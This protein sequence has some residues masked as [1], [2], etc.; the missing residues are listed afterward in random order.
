MNPIRHR[1]RCLHRIFLAICCTLGF[2]VLAFPPAPHQEVYGL[3]RDEL[4]NPVTASGATV[5]LEANGNILAS[6]TIAM[7]T[8]PGVNYRLLIA[9]D[10]G[11]T[12]DLYKPSALVPTVPFR[13]R[14]KIGN[15]TY[16]PIELSGASA[17]VAQPGK[18]ARVDLTLGVDSNGDGL[19]DAWQYAVI[20]AIGK[21]GLTLADISPGGDADGDGMTNLQEFLA[22]TYAFDPKDGFTVAL[23]S[24]EGTSANL[25]FTV[26]NRRSYTVEGSNDLHNWT[27]LSFVVPSEGATA[28]ARTSYL[29]T[30]TRVLRV[31]VGPF[32]DEITAPKFFRLMVY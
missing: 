26:I 2:G 5:L 30:N 24:I 8:E 29:A 22:G 12:A 20:R 18:A 27:P 19:P 11:V 31:A 13:I 17:L 21:P 32:S 6:G 14:V 28:A 4:G 16:L 7:G 23:K 10:S 1:A 9:I 3:I 25:E 15:T